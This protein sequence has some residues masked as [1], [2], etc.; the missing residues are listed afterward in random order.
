MFTEITY[1]WQQWANSSKGLRLLR[2]W[3]LQHTQLRGWTMDELQNPRSCNRTDQ[4]Q[5]CLVRLSQAGCDNA[6]LTLAQQLS[7]GLKKLTRTIGKSE[8]SHSAS[9]VIS[10]FYETLL[11]HNLEARPNKI[12]AN[13]ILDT[14]QKF[15]RSHLAEV[16]RTEAFKQAAFTAQTEIQPVTQI[17]NSLCALNAVGKAMKKYHRG[18]P[19]S[20]ASEIAFQHWVLG[21]PTKEIAEAH[22]V[23]QSVITSRLWRLRKT[24]RQEIPASDYQ[25]AA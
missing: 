24:L 10:T 22:G 1:K 6:A 11:R 15:H 19:N 14:R 21:M 25:E 17:V 2:K 8:I 20:N 13:L 9:E 4:M 18:A 16:K 7:P 5:A 23:S 12:A 3:Q